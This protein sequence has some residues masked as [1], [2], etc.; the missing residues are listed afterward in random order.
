[1]EDAYNVTGTLIW[2]YYICH[3]QV[4]L[5]ARGILPDED[6]PNLE[7]GRFIQEMTYQRDRKEIDIGGGK[8]DIVK[9]ASDGLI[10]VEVKKS[11]RFERVALMQLAFYLWRLEAAGVHATGELRFPKEK[12]RTTVVLTDELR[13]ELKRAEKAILEIAAREAPP[14]P[15]RCRYCSNCAYAEFCWA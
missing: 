6:N 4:W 2:Y 7:L 12:K 9:A 8:V 11:S 15:A 10:L 14:V 3:R 13:E 1:M 5:M